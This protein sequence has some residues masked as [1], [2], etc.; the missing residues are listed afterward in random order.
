MLQGIVNPTVPD[1]ADLASAREVPGRK[2]IRLAAAQRPAELG[3]KP[4]A[5]L[6]HFEIR[7]SHL[8]LHDQLQLALELI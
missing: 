2:A 5:V 3:H 4:R 8:S 6:A 7:A 1:A